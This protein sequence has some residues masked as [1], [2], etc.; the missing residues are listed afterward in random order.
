MIHEE[1]KK[2][3]WEATEFEHREKSV[4]W[5]WALG[6]ATVTGIILSVIGHNYFLAILLALGG[7]MLGFY[8]NDK[9]RPV[10]VE[11]S[12]RG[13]KLNEDLYTHETL[14]SFWIYTDHRGRKQL[15][16]VTGRPVLPQ[17]I[18]T[19]PS[20]IPAN[21]IRQYLMAFVEE[22]ET[23]PSAV[24]ILAESIGV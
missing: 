19:L 7:L 18:V 22:K 5:Y 20:D 12:S 4:D 24:D 2:Y 14:Q 10:H 15:I 9:P 6:I 8:A 11:L 13:I 21:I 3:S 17:R 23:R 16:I 1:T